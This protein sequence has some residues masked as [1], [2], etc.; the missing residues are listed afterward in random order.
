MSEHTPLLKVSDLTV[1]YP[2]G[3]VGIEGVT[4][5][6]GAGEKVGLVGESGSGKSTAAMAV[7]GLLP[8]RSSVTGSVSFDGSELVGART[9][10]VRKVRW[11]GISMIFQNSM[12][13]LNPVTRVGGQVVD[14][15]RF[16][17]GVDRAAATEIVRELFE[18]VGL[19]AARMR[20]YPHELSGGMRQR[21]MVALALSCDPQL[22]IADE[23]TTALDVVMQ[24]RVLDLIG[25]LQEERGLALVL[26]SH[27]LAVVAETCDRVYV[28]NQGRVVEHGAVEDVLQH[29]TDPY[30][31][32]LIS[33]YRALESPLSERVIS[34]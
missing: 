24:R 7:M 9:D 26:V 15:V 21:V 30:T 5:D 18:T 10:V 28:M 19:D 31:Q 29:P 2:N 14:A 1:T 27:D 4:I 13:A 25:R 6:V 22:V 23:P 11:T 16:H 12:T 33:S 3:A 34:E 20:A 8:G 32:R 17:R